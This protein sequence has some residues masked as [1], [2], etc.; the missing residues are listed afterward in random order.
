MTTLT[1]EEVMQAL[2][3]EAKERSQKEGID[4][5]E[6]KMSDEDIMKRIKDRRLR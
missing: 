6:V 2:F 3:E 1:E 4:L 5:T